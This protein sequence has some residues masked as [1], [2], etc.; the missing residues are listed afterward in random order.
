MDCILPKVLYNVPV[1]YP[2]TP[3]KASVLDDLLYPTA[4]PPNMGQECIKYIQY[5]VLLIA[6]RQESSN[7]LKPFIRTLKST[8]NQ[9]IDDIIPQLYNSTELFS[10][11]F[12]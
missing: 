1:I 2:F 11:L 9:M 5:K 4:A 3:S 8:L 7:L 6:R 12:S 10:P